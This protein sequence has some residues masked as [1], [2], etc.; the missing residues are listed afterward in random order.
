[1]IVART[2][3]QLLRRV[4][5]RSHSVVLVPV[6]MPPGVLP[7]RPHR[8]L[9]ARIPL[10]VTILSPFVPPRDLSGA[11]VSAIE[12]VLRGRGEF[13]YELTRVG[14]FPT[15]RYLVIEPHEP[16][17]DLIA[18]FE[19]A[20]PQ[21]PRY[22]GQF[23]TTI[24]HV[25]IADGRR[26]DDIDAAVAARLPVPMVARD[27]EVWRKHAIRGW[28]LYSRSALAP[29]ESARRSAGGQGYVTGAGQGS[30]RRVSSKAM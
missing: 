23:A 5:P 9:R 19:R 20:W 22:G 18:A 29:V 7:A 12:S 11:V 24:P 6:Q 13:T 25:T 1:V 17:L 8:R 21:Y 26:M 15:A 27:V 16:F 14:S 4:I 10:H 28:R 2:V 30:D 3:M